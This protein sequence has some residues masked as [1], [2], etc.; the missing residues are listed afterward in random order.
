MSVTLLVKCLVEHNFSLAGELNQYLFTLPIPYA[1]GNTD[2]H[3]EISEL[4]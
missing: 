3:T 2:M 4:E 1:T